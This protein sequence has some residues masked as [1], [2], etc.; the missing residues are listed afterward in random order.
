MAESAAKAA[1]VDL[2][3]KKGEVIGG[4]YRLEDV[5]GLGGTAVVMSAT[6]QQLQQKVAVKLLLKN[7]ATAG[8][9]AERLLRE[10]Q[11]IAQMRSPHV[12]RV[13]DVGTLSNGSP[14]MVMELLEGI[15]LE[16]HLQLRGRLPIAEAV[17]IVMQVCEA[18]AEAHGLG[19]VHRDLKPGNVFITRDV[20]KRPLVKVLDFGLSKLSIR[21]KQQVQKK[22]TSP[23]EVMGT[24]AYMSPEQL[25]AT[26]DVDERSD[27][28][29]LGV[30]LYELCTGE[31]PFDDESV[32]ALCVKVMRDPFKRV[33]VDLPSGLETII[34]RCLQKEPDHRFP[35]VSA[36][37]IALAPFAEKKE[38]LDRVLRVQPLSLPP[39]NMMRPEEVPPYRPPGA[40]TQ[41]AVV[42]DTSIRFEDD[43]EDPFKRKKGGW[44]LF[45]FGVAGALAGGAILVG[46]AMYAGKASDTPAAASTPPPSAEPTPAP[47]AT[48]TPPPAEDNAGANAN[49]ANSSA[50]KPGA[51]APGKRPG[52]L[53]GGAA[54]PAA[55]RGSATAPATSAGAPAKAVDPDKLLETR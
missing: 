24:P 40:P 30:L 31:L 41:A 11:V 13:V 8:V 36:L 35:K 12:A 23:L 33:S 39:D 48:A 17:D 20:D 46:V 28:W 9:D 44:S 19:V 42:T 51:L 38:R 7:A 49:L 18:V 47:T 55:A 29:S 4:K 1:T 26:S 45:G 53:V 10:A 21:A 43:D 3:V 2:P 37:A 22:I 16:G 6:H 52:T 14:F 27:I 50:T 34:T 5:L 54:K 15:D 25:R 32:Q